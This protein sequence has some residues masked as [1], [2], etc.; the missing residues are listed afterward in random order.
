[1]N[2]KR[3]VSRN[4][5]ENSDGGVYNPGVLNIDDV[6]HLLCRV[7]PNYDAYE[8]KLFGSPQLPTLVKISDIQRTPKLE[9]FGIEHDFDKDTERI[10]DFRIMEGNGSDEFDS[11]IK[12]V[13]HTYISSY[14]KS[15]C[16][17]V[18]EFDIRSLTLKKKWIFKSPFNRKIEKNWLLVEINGNIFLIYTI[19]PLIVYVYRN[20]RFEPYKFYD[21]LKLFKK[22]FNTD[23]FIRGSSNPIKVGNEYYSC[24]H[25][26]NHHKYWHGYFVFDGDF[27]VK[28]VS[29]PI[30]TPEAKKDGFY[31][32]SS[33]I[34]DHKSMNFELYVG[35]SDED[36]G[37]FTYTKEEFDNFCN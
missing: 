23:S 29:D 21:N 18:S 8:G 34:Y 3:L 12:L 35:E 5:I 9:I 37:V 4:F 32:G 2:Y 11:L 22:W 31:Y 24:F 20:R 7:E 10:E 27:N 36:T 26:R 15:I 33:L 19:Q 28:R 17:A 13:S 1:M 16:M 14:D 6:R 25:T 30:L